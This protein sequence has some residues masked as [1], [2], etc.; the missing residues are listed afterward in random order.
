M[1]KAFK[2]TVMVADMREPSKKDSNT[3]MTLVKLL[4]RKK[5]NSKPMEGSRT[6]ACIN[7]HQ[8]RF[9]VVSF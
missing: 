2:N 9:I 1:V 4:K 6:K 3:A 7:Q 8:E 5:K